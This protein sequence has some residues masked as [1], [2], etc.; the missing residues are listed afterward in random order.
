VRAEV[1]GQ[2]L[3]HGEVNNNLGLPGAYSDTV[4]RFMRSLDAGQH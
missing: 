3:S 1:T 4:E 2:A